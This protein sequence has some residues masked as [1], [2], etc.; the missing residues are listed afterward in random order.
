MVPYTPTASVSP[1]RRRP[2][3]VPVWLP[4]APSFCARRGSMM[5]PRARSRPIWSHACARLLPSARP[6]Y[7]PHL[8]SLP[9]TFTKN[10]ELDRVL[11][12]AIADFTFE[13]YF[14]AS[15]TDG[16]GVLQRAPEPV[17]LRK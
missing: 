5:R 10:G 3:Y 8:Q 7:V 14:V 12:D 15:T 2:A 13:R 16:R 9:G 1:T 17:E 4:S 11:V 6:P